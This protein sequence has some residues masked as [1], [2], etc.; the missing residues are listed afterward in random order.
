M[1]AGYPAAGNARFCYPGN[2]NIGHNGEVRSYPLDDEGRDI[3][4]YEN[5]NYGSSKSE[6]VLGYYNDYYGVYWH[7]KDF[8]SIHHA[9][10]DEKLGMKI[11]LWGLARSGA[12]WEDL[13]TDTNGQYIELQSGRMYNQPSSGSSFSPY[14]QYSF[15]PGVTDTWTEYWFPVKGIG[16]VSKASAV[17]ALSVERKAGGV[18]LAFSPNVALNTEVKLYDGAQLIKSLPMQTRP[19]EA[20][21]AQVDLAAVPAEGSLR[22]VIGDD[23]LVYTEDKADFELSRPTALPADFDWNSVQGLYTQGEQWMNQKVNDK[24]EHYLKAALDKDKYYAP[25]LR[26]LASLY[27]RQGKTDEALRLLTTALSLDTYDGE[28]NYLYGLCNKQLGRTV[29]AKDGFSIATYSAAYRS[30]AYAALAQLYLREGDSRKAEDYALKSLKY[31]DMNLDARQALAVVYREDGKTAEANAQLDAV[32]AALPLYHPMRYERY[33]LAK[34][35]QSKAEFLAMVRNEL[36]DETFMELAD[37]YQSAGRDAEALELLSFAPN[38]PIALYKSAYIQSLAGREAEARQLLAQAE[39]LLPDMVFPF[40]ATD[41]AALQWAASVSPSWKNSYYQALIYWAN[42]DKARALNLLDACDADYAP[43][44]TARASL[45]EGDARLADLLKAQ[46]LDKSWRAGVSLMNYYAAAKDW[47][48]AAEVGAKYHKSYPSNYYIGLRYANALCRTGQYDKCV[49]LL[50]SMEVLPNE[51]A[52]QGKTIFRNANL[53]QAAELI[54]KRDFKRAAKYI[55]AS[56]EW[57]ENLGV[58]KPYDNLIDTRLEDYL[59]ANSAALQGNTAAASELYGKVASGKLS[60]S[61]F[62]SLDLLTAVAMR[63]TG[64]KAD[65]DKVAASWSSAFAGNKAAEWCALVYDGKTAE[66][67]ALI[68]ARTETSDDATPWEAS[69]TDDNFDIITKVFAAD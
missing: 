64:R 62:N 11:F 24:A 31:N 47:K 52:R 69:F 41:L 48:A 19:L 58:G 8:G 12:I 67:A 26:R 18:S 65:A 27:I 38:N 63:E 66:A 51:G 15:T 56:R 42:Q 1:N 21:H 45:K 30:P 55:E 4:W 44:L 16:G 23:D 43:L 35:P 50:R 5:N 49:A 53:Y 39:A 54:R 7:D 9:R 61:N 57:P 32:L 28:A 2:K 14:K 40:K 36:P 33:L 37:W 59:S 60:T 6:H 29:D 10:Y 25:A 34:T 17:G 46:K 3:S 13:L 68:A 22:V 20:W